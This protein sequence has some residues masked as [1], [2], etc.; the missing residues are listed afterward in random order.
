[1]GI[2]LALQLG[3]NPVKVNCVVMKDFNEDEIVDFV[4]FTKDRRVDIR[5]IEYMPFTGNKWE[6]DKL[7]PYKSM[8]KVIHA[9]W[10]DFHPLDNAPNDTSKNERE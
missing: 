2:D 4:R 6:V 8:L 1:M 7:I 3:Y 9:V 5:F 10:P